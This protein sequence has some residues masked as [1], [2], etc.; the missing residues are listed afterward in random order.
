MKNILVVD[1]DTSFLSSLVE[2]FYLI[3][4]S[5]HII[6]AENSDQALMILRSVPVDLVIP[7]IRMQV[8]TD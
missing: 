1:D 3:A 4:R 5:Y 2:M 7:D 6:T 8:I